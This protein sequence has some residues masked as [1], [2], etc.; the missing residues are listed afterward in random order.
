MRLEITPRPVKLMS[1]VSCIGYLKL[2]WNYTLCAKLALLNE[3]LLIQRSF[4]KQKW[5]S[6]W[7][8]NDTLREK[9]H[10]GH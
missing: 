9:G 6:F 10:Q 2:E 1:T 8:L 5:H 4:F 7:A 3:E